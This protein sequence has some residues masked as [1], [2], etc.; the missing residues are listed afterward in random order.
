MNVRNALTLEEG[1]WPIS[2]YYHAVYLRD[3]WGEPRN[4]YNVTA[5]N[6]AEIL[7]GNLLVQTK[8]V[9][10]KQPARFSTA[11]ISMCEFYWF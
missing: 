4:T 11:V 10:S 5:D 6:L 1:W 2:R 3:T 8:S 7:T 9:S